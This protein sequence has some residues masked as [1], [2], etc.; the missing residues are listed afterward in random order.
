MIPKPALAAALLPISPAHSQKILAEDYGSDPAYGDGW[1]SGSKG[2]R[3]FGLWTH[4][5]AGNL[6]EYSHNGF[7]TRDSH[8]T[9][10]DKVLT[11][12]ANGEYYETSFAFRPFEKPLELGQSFSLVMDSGPFECC[13]DNDDPTPGRTGFSLRSAND[14]ETWDQYEL[15]AQLVFGF[16]EGEENYQLLDGSDSPDAGVPFN[17]T[18]VYVG[19][20][21]TGPDTYDIEINTLGETQVPTILKDRKLAAPDGA[22]IASLTIF[23][24][25]GEKNAAAFNAFRVFR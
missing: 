12:W 1:N 10:G 15:D 18:G 8:P 21:L 2:G 19:V 16:F 9:L 23:N 11:M 3:G 22:P 7:G 24:L 25:D 4:R 6:R 20:K 17:P 14:S 13:F 5:G